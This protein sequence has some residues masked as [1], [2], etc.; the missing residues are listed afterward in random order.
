MDVSCF[1]Y[2]PR[3]GTRE[4]EKE[5]AFN[6]MGQVLGSFFLMIC[7]SAQAKAQTVTLVEDLS[8]TPTHPIIKD[9]VRQR[10]F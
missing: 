2:S 10:F 7:L 4:R 8:P 1:S 3:N 6:P 9:S 5:Y